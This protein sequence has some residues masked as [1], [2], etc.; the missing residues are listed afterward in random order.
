MKII[1]MDYNKE[2]PAYPRFNF[3]YYLP[4]KGD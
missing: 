1:N 2:R 3:L 4:Q